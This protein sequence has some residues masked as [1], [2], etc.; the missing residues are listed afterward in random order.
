MFNK[1]QKIKLFLGLILPVF[2]HNGLMLHAAEVNSR[3]RFLGLRVAKRY[4]RIISYKPYRKKR[5][6]RLNER[7]RSNFRYITPMFGIKSRN[8][9]F[10]VYMAAFDRA[11]N[12]IYILNELKWYKHF[13]I[14][15]NPYA[16]RGK[17]PG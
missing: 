1:T 6:I 14:L 16:V 5:S 4:F 7:S 15:F 13:V 3:T 12:R 9:S 2:I 11:N 8:Q 10:S 17:E